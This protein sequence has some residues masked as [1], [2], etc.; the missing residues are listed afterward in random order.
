MKK[1]VKKL[2]FRRRREGLTDYSKRLA[3]VKSGLYRVVIRKTNRRIIGQ[4]IAYAPNGDRVLATASSAELAKLGWP[5]RANRATAYLTG[6]LLANKFKKQDK[7]A[8]LDI[9]LSSNIKGSV[10]FAFAQGC[11]AGGMKLRG[12]FEMK[13]SEY[14]LSNVANYAKLLSKEPE[15]LN[16]QFGAYMKAGIKPEQLPELFKSVVQKIKA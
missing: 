10:P 7:D 5:S 12:K 9:G 2:E 3:L 8:I 14:N 1:L 15:K 6:M 4:V 16:K 13:E 11:V